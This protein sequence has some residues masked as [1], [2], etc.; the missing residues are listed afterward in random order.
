MKKITYI[1]FI[2]IFCAVSCDRF[3]DMK[4]IDPMT[5]DEDVFSKR[6]TTEQYLYNIYS[7]VPKYYL[8]G[9]N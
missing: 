7:Y 8:A 1:L 2:F 3:L 6:A 4:P 5:T 9:V